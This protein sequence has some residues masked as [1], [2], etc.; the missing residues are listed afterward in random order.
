MRLKTGVI[1]LLLILLPTPRATAQEIIIEKHCR[2]AYTEVIN[3]KFEDARIL[4]EQEKEDNPENLYPLYLENYI[5]FLSLFIGEN[6]L[7]FNKIEDHESERLDLLDQLPDNNP[8]KNYLK[9]NIRL[10]W[11]IAGLKFQNYFS[12]ALD[13]RRSYILIKENREKFPEFKPQLITSG[14]LHIIIGMVPDQ[15][16]WILSLISMEGNVSQGEEELY[17]A[18]EIIKNN[19]NL[20]YLEPEVLFYLGFMEMN[21]GL[22]KNKKELLLETLTPFTNNNLLLTFLKANML[23]RSD[24]NDEALELLNKATQ[25]KGYYPFTYLYYLKG[26]YRLRKLDQTAPKE[27]R[28][29]INHFEGINFIKD[30]WRKTGWSY[31]INGD[32]TGYLEVMKKVLTAGETNVDADKDANKEALSGKIPNVVLLKVR[33]LSDGGY[34]DKARALL[35]NNDLSGFSKE[36]KIEQLYR[37]GRIE[38][39]TKNTANSKKYFV[40]TIKA[41]K[42]S[43]RYFAGNAALQLGMIFESEKDYPSALKYYRLCRELD[44]DE[45]ETSIKEKAKQGIKRIEENK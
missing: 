24:R 26:E 25:W 40:K 12:S 18:L 28:Y 20:N 44:F 34:F 36:D 3:L 13:I 32:T 42:N 7:L 4:I 22:D 6:E 14:V 39:K 1:F 45:Y 8:Y 29:Y 38:Q 16:Q 17:R 15:Y 19:N 9:A 5:D 33:L 2:D 21:L 31:L 35:K 30:A 41:G 37:L 10:Q 11:A 27:Y 43:K 23:A